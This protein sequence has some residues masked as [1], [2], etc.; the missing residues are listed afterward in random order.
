[1]DVFAS[2]AQPWD[3][4]DLRAGLLLNLLLGYMSTLE[5]KREIMRTCRT[6]AC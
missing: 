6:V 2:N 4:M 3:H 5:A 1:M